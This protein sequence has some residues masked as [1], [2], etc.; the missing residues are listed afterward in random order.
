MTTD[1][2][3]ERLR[4]VQRSLATAG[5][6]SLIFDDVAELIA[7]IEKDGVQYA[8][9]V[10]VRRGSGNSAHGDETIADTVTILAR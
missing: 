1:R 3:L 9:A 6:V 10:P 8:L 5:F 4:T 7:E 2:L